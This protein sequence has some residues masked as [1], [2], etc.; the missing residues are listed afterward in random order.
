MEELRDI[1][2]DSITAITTSLVERGLPAGLVIHEN[3]NRP[4]PNNRVLTFV[5]IYPTSIYQL[6]AMFCDLL[7]KAVLAGDVDLSGHW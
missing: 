7:Y 2:N 6:Q 1:D 5:A 4:D 3:K